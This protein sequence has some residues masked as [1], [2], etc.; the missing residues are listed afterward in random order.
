MPRPRRPRAASPLYDVLKS[1]SAR[2]YDEGELVALF[3][4]V[5]E[6]R[7]GQISDAIGAYLRE[8]LPRAI[9]SR[10]GLADYRSNPY[11]LLTSASVMRLGEPTYF[12]DFLLN[13]K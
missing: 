7:V 12:A 13:T 11:V 4:R 3:G 2:R 5:D 6:T 8:N 9:E 1:S 10:S